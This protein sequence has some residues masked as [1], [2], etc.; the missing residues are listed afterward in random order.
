MIRT[1]FS[2][3]MEF[4]MKLVYRS[5]SCPICLICIEC[6]KIYGSS[7]SCKSKEIYWDKN[8]KYPVDFRHKLLTTYSTNNRM[9][10]D[11]IFVSWFFEKASP[12]IKIPENHS[13]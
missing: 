5:N 9:K 6:A 8:N 1:T 13:D 11:S 7:C 3:N 2:S 12:Q 4:K 10:L